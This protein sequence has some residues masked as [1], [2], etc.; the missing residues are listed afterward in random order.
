MVTSYPAEGSSGIKRV[1]ANGGTPEILVETEE[2][3]FYVTPQI[4]P[5]GKSL[6]FASISSSDGTYKTV[7]QSLESG[8]RKELLEG[9]FVAYLPTGHLL[10]GLVGEDTPGIGNFFAVP[11]YRSIKILP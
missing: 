4:L 11:F 1:S 10:Y 8:E 9:V 5:D 7:L 2:N 3:T 6:L